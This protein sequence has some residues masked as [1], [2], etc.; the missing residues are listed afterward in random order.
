M[1]NDDTLSGEVQAF[2]ATI[3]AECRFGNTPEERETNERAQ[4]FI[5]IIVDDLI[6]SREALTDNKLAIIDKLVQSTPELIADFL[7]SRF[8]RDVIDAVPG[9]VK[10]IMQLSRL[11]GAAI[12]SNVTNGY[13]REAVRTYVFG[14]AQASTALSRAALEQALKER[15]GMQLSGDFIKFQDLLKEA[16]KWNILDDVMEQCARDVANAG[17]DVMHDRPANLSKALEVLDK[18]RGLFRHIYST[19][20]HY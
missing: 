1:K 20:G 14:L 8:T 13:M 2:I 18:L 10:R 17:D 6:S 11:E 15:L 7:D 9:Y 16:R 3:D 4:R 19:E 12:P 5:D